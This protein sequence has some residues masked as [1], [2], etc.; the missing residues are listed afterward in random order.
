MAKAEQDPEFVSALER[1]EIDAGEWRAALDEARSVV[2]ERQPEYDARVEQAATPL[3]ALLDPPPLKS[4]GSVTLYPNRIAI[5][6]VVHNLDAETNTVAETRGNINR[7]KRSLLTRVAVGVATG[8]PGFYATKTKKH[9]DREVV[10]IVEGSDW[11]EMA[12]FAPA[13]QRDVVRFAKEIEAAGAA[14]AAGASDRRPEATRLAQDVRPMRD[15]RAELDDAMSTLA[16]V[17]S[18]AHVQAH[19]EALR[20]IVEQ[21]G[22]SVS[23]SE[24]KR[25]DAIQ[26]LVDAEESLPPPPPPPPPPPTSYSPSRTRTVRL[27]DFRTESL[28]LMVRRSANDLSRGLGRWKSNPPQ[29]RPETPLTIEELLAIAEQAEAGEPPAAAISPPPP[30]APEATVDALSRLAEMHQAGILSDDEFTA[31]KQRLLGS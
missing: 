9:D 5:N 14:W 6:G 18:Q 28:G 26:T 20:S 21:G 7:V 13:L 12:T 19:L 3:R 1:L 4:L 8:G 10:L 22:L 2:A 23:R 24:R 17:R 11:A 31:A 15:D 30:P 16:T 25:I 29:G 27:A